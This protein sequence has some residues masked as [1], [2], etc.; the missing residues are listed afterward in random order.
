MNNSSVESSD[1]HFGRYNYIVANIALGF[2]SVGAG[3][4]VGSVLGK[5]AVTASVIIIYLLLL[6]WL[7]GKRLQ[8]IGLPKEY[9]FLIFI[10]LIGFFIH[11]LC[12]SAPKGLT[13]T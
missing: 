9:S 4:L 12:L 2:L 10:P 6:I 1:D 8:H 5:A 13:T 7:T 11:M 3:L